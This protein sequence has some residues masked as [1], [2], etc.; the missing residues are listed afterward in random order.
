MIIDNNK[1]ID[2]FAE[3]DLPRYYHRCADVVLA[4]D[5]YKAKKIVYFGNE[6]DDL[7]NNHIQLRVC[8]DDSFIIT[9][10]TTSDELIEECF[11][12]VDKHPNTDVE[13]RTPYDKNLQNNSII[14]RFSVREAKYP[15]NPVYYMHTRQELIKTPTK[16][17]VAVSLLDQCS[18]EEIR[19]NI[20]RGLLDGEEM[21]PDETMDPNVF[22]AMGYKDIK[23]FIIRVN[24]NVIGYLRGENGFSNVYDIGWVYIDPKYRNRGYAAHLVKCFSE[25]MFD[26][27]FIPHYGHA[28]SKQ[29]VCVAEKCGFKCD[30]EHSVCVGLKRL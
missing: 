10:N 19:D 24:G 2:L 18:I 27:G 25:Y 15:L 6:D 28:I 8:F 29:S 9:V 11:S 1:M 21:D 7:V 3:Y 23:T 26:N 5:D 4:S 17:D 12:Y 20:R 16:K 22:Y 14:S 30:D 13:M